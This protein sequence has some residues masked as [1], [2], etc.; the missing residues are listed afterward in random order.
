SQHCQQVF[1]TIWCGAAQ[2]DLARYDD[3]QLIS[4]ITFVKYR[5]SAGKL[6]LGQLRGQSAEHLIIEVC[7][8]RCIAQYVQIHCFVAFLT[9]LVGRTRTLAETWLFMW[10]AD[11]YRFGHINTSAFQGGL[12]S[13]STECRSPCGNRHNHRRSYSSTIN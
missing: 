5:G 8:E 12:P 11:N 7:E 2:F 9:G 10:V 13:D 1:T 6:N 3:V 4:I